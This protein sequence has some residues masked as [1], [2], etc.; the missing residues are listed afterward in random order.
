MKK[1]SIFFALLGLGIVGLA[2]DTFT[3]TTF[4]EMLEEYK[5]DSK[6][7][8]INRLSDDFRYSNEDGKFLY[9]NEIIKGEPQ[10]IVSTDVAE[11]VIFQS[12]ELATVSGLH[13][14]IRIGKD[15]N[16]TVDLVTCTYTFQKR[17]GKWM[18][19]ASQQTR[20]A[21]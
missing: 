12:C 20:L 18:F 16:E 1:Y 2:Q 21:Q 14:T 15:G 11:P 17:N 9:K 7:F 3:K 4:Q 6:A 10:K 8:F 19:V 13:K 5:K